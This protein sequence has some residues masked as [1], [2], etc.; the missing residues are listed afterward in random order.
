LSNHRVAASTEPFLFLQRAITEKIRRRKT[1]LKNHWLD[2]AEEKHGVKLVTETKTV[3]NI[4]VLYLPL[5]I[6]WAVYSQQAS[7]W[8]FQATRMNKDLG[9]YTILPDQIVTL[10]PLLVIIA[11]PLCDYVIYPILKQFKIETLLQKMTIGG[12]LGVIAIS[13][14]AVVETQ[15]AANFISVLWLVPQYFFI[16]LSEN[17]LFASHLN[18]VYNEASTNMKSVMTASVYV[19]V[20]FGNLFVV[21]ISGLRIFESQTIEFLFYAGIL[22]LATIVFGLLASKYKSSDRGKNEEEVGEK[23]GLMGKGEIDRMET[24]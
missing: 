12:L 7:R 13:A 15:I 14:S 8:V 21:L 6:Y 2:Y 4:L 11:I 3:M 17:F 5:P 24:S 16:A 19:I 10:S 23:S 22:L 18:F 9:F 1:D 20:A